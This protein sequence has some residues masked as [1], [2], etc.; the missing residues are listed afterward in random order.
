MSSDS[1]YTNEMH[2]L[3]FISSWWNTPRTANTKKKIWER[4]QTS[5]VRVFFRCPSGCVSEWTVGLDGT[6]NLITIIIM[7]FQIAVWEFHNTPWLFI[8][9]AHAISL[10][11]IGQVILTI[12]ETQTAWRWGGWEES[13]KKLIKI[14]AC[15]DP[16]T[17]SFA[18]LS[19]KL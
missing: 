8:L 17:H 1:V 3:I 10:E 4:K 19:M 5:S 15:L 12:V 14:T 13:E 16:A 9:P 18:M 7:I 11:N 2:S 6:L